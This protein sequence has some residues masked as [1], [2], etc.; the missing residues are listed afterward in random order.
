M[1]LPSGALAADACFSAAR[2]RSPPNC[3][4][5][6]W[7][8]RHTPICHAEPESTSSPPFQ[9]RPWQSMQKPLRARRLARRRS[10]GVTQGGRLRWYSGE[11]AM[12]V[13]ASATMIPIGSEI[14]QRSRRYS[15]ALVQVL[16][17]EAPQRHP[18]WDSAGGGG[19][20]FDA[21]RQALFQSMPRVFSH[22]MDR[23]P[24]SA[25]HALARIVS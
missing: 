22:V 15:G 17:S 7:F 14:E 13:R 4:R 5:Q 11:S 21:T 18:V 25:A 2:Y 9:L 1:C 10:N 8:I 12:R 19:E 23:I 3:P 24:K 20:P 16:A 6:L